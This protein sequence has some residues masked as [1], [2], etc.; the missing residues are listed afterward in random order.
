MDYVLI[1]RS[2]IRIKLQGTYLHKTFSKQEE[3]KIILDKEIRKGCL[4]GILRKG[5]NSYS[6]PIMSI[7]RKVTGIPYIITD[8]RHLN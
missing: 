7:P 1:C 2:K 8:V 6:S 5:L 3:E 4:L